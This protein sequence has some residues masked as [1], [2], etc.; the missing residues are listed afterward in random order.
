V[1]RRRWAARAV[2]GVA[3]LGLAVPAG[4]IETVVFGIE[5]WPTVVDGQR[6][7]SLHE[8][9]PP[10]GS[11]TDAVRLWNKTKRPVTLAVKAVAARREADGSVSLGGDPTPASWVEVEPSEVTVPAGGQRVVEFTIRAP[12]DLPETTS[13]FALLAEPVVGRDEQPAVLQRL[14]LMAYV[15][16][17]EGSSSVADAALGALPWVAGALLVLVLAGLLVVRRRQSVAP[18]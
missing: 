10:G 8:A 6:R 16:P 5:P 13:T 2:A 7:Q 3:C 9:V 15:R 1:S 18:P 11:K 17:G 14:A 4:A 12:R